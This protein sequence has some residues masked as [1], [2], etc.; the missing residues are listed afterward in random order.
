[1][2]DLENIWRDRDLSSALKVRV[3]KVLVWTTVNY[4]AEGWTLRAEE[5][6][7]NSVS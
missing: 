3:M 1:M 5:K 6:K 4:G 7:K 2:V